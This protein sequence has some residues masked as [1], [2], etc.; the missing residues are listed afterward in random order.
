MAHPMFGNLAEKLQELLSSMQESGEKT[1][2]L[3]K[4]KI[5][6]LEHQVEVFEH[7]GSS[8]EK[9]ADAL[10]FAPNGNG[11]LEMKEH[12]ETLSNTQ[13]KRQRDEWQCIS[14]TTQQTFNWSL[15]CGSNILQ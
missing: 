3:Q 12:F 4:Q 5:E 6:A 8:L 7:I 10:I 1:H 11:M 13:R 9:I 14:E 15:C 2:A